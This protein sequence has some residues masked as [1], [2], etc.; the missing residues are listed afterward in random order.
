MSRESLLTQVLFVFGIGFFAANMKV[1]ADLIRFR[2]RKTSALLV[3]EN[4]K[5]P[6][7]G[8][9]LALGAV[10][11]LLVA[12]KIFILG[13]SPNQLFGEVMMFVY[14][15]YAFPLSTRIARGFYR[16]GVWSDRGFMPWG[17]ISAVS[18]KEEGAVT[19]VLISHFRHIARR[20]EVPGHLYGQ[21]RRVL[22]DKIKAHD[23]HIGGAGL[24]LGSRDEADAV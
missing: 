21:A 20:L 9:A 7:Y 10:L 6:Y 19:L 12:F 11:G 1:A 5:P 14:Y 17:Q 8:F 22:R 23:I 15:G 13:R 16:G 18:W 2:I 24:D 4:P 3:W